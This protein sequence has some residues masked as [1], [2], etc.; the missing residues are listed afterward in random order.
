[1]NTLGDVRM[2]NRI[3]SSWFNQTWLTRLLRAKAYGEQ[4]APKTTRELNYLKYKDGA[5]TTASKE[6]QL[7]VVGKNPAPLFL[8][9][10]CL[11]FV[12]C[13]NHGR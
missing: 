3:N 10:G 4:G 11:L 6:E 7:N 8:N 12:L 13:Y 2:S 9:F 1:M 5:S